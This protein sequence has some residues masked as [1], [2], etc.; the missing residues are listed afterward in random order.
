MH[1][2][3]SFHG[4]ASFYRRFI[5]H[6]SSTAA[7]MTEVLKGVKFI[8]TPQYQWSF[9]ELKEKLTHAPILAL[10]YFK[11]VFEA[12]CGASG[13]GIG[14]VLIQEGKPLAYF[15]E[16][17]SESRRKYSTDKEFFA[18]IWGLEHWTHYLIAN[19]FILH[20]DHEALKY[21]QGEHKF[22]SRHAKW[23][24]YLQSFHFVIK[25]KSNTANQGV[26]ALLRRHL[27]LF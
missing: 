20:S 9:E 11:K 3:R 10:P 8:W 19:K 22:N 25:H 18:I 1:D 15:S 5:R 12:K 14:A 13:V 17:L 6:F 16:K 23:A 24:E 21:I 27:L 26:D 4:L 7:P 2:V